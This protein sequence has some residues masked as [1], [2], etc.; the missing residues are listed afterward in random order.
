MPKEKKGVDRMELQGLQ[1]FSAPQTDLK[2]CTVHAFDPEDPKNR[3]EHCHT[4]LERL[5][6]CTVSHTLCLS[7]AAQ[8]HCE[9]ELRA[10]NGSGCAREEEKAQ[11]REQESRGS[12]AAECQLGLA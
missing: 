1:L 8:R 6:L 5:R 3:L 4:G 2:H 9:S 12:A 7:D 11:E 10:I